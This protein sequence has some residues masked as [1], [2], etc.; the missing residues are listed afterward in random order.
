MEKELE[1]SLQQMMEHL[2]ASQAEDVRAQLAT[3]HKEAEDGE[4]ARLEMN[5]AFLKEI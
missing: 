3:S 2:L 4:H 5:L 1:Q